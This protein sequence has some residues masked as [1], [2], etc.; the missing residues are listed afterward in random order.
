MGEEIKANGYNRAFRDP[1]YSC[2]PIMGN[3]GVGLGEDEKETMS[4]QSGGKRKVFNVKSWEN[5]QRI[6]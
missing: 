3:Q 1:F 2:P 5:I 6:S 4:G